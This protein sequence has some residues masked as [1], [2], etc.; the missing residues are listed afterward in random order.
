MKQKYAME[1]IFLLVFLTRASIFSDDRTDLL[2]VA[3]LPYSLERL[4]NSSL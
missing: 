1:A 3:V 2:S 4:V